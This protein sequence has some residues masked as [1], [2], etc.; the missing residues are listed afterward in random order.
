MMN[1]RFFSGTQVEAYTANGK[2]RFAKSNSKKLDADE[3]ETEG[4]DKD[5]E[6]A[7]RID[8]FDK[9]LKEGEEESKVD[10]EA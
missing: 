6:E 7:K 1:G 5:T 8:K 9:W 3:D 4:G 2:E 10:D